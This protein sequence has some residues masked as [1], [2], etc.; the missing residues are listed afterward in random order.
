MADPEKKKLSARQ[1]LADIRSGME[2]P[3]LKSKYG[4]SDKALESVFRQLSHKGLLTDRQVGRS[5]PSAANPAPT[6]NTASTTQWRC[7]ACNAVHPSAMNECPSCGVVLAKFLA[8]G[9]PGYS[10]AR[11]LRVAGQDASSGGSGWTY[12][13]ASLAVL[14]LVGGAVVWW[15]THRSGQKA[16]IAASTAQNYQSS[17]EIRVAPEG[18]T[19]EEPTM[20]IDSPDS[21]IASV[22]GSTFDAGS[23]EARQRESGQ[24][25]EYTTGVLR[26]FTSADF[27][28]EVVEASKTYP[29]LFQFYSDT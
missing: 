20:S 4:L 29:V 11:A 28:T 9:G 25:T 5:I 21:G 26:Q 8:R 2:E 24:S 10:D 23:V 18:R 17:Q 16:K 7:P 1:I 12:V 6:G 3:D 22:S 27:K 15:S 14:V 13:V 19:G